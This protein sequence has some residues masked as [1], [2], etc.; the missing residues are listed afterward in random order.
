MQPPAPGKKKANLRARTAPVQA[1]S[2]DS[3]RRVLD[4]TMDLL[5][6]HGIHK[7][8]TPAIAS[9]CGLSIGAL[10]RYFPNKEAII[11]ELYEER[12]AEMRRL[13]TEERPV[14]GA[15]SWRAYFSDY[16]VRLK[17]AERQADLDA[18]LI[19]AM[20]MVPELWEIDKR[21]GVLIA[22]Q[23]VE[24]MKR[25]GSSWS[26][27]ALFE[28]AITLYSLDSTI[29]MH[30][31]FSQRHPE[32]AVRRV[33]AAALDMMQPAMEGAEEPAEISVSRQQLRADIGV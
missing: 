12:L 21:H 15:R 25:F 18:S 1:R 10:Y 8:T 11:Y 23:L 31:R 13:G 33:T 28:L 26:D 30:W 22:D 3:R 9:A 29:W 2:V 27:A 16:L 17:E 5:K 24:E 6:A 7:L 20:V 19:E 14:R 32:L 4:A